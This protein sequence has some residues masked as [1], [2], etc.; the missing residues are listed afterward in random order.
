[1]EKLFAFLIGCAVILVV[2]G[3]WHLGVA[4]LLMWAWNLAVPALFHGP[5]ITY[6]ASLVMTVLASLLAGLFKGGSR[7][8]SSSSKDS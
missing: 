6:L 3:L 7:V 2:G 5:H 1:V 4:W 8:A